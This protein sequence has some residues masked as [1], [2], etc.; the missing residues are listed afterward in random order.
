MLCIWVRAW[1][2]SGEGIGFLAA[3]TIPN[4]LSIERPSSIFFW[5]V[6]CAS[7]PFFCRFLF[8]FLFCF[9]FSFSRWNFVTVDDP[10]LFTC[11]AD[12]V[13]VWQPRMSVLS[14]CLLYANSGCGK[15]RRILIGPWLPAKAALVRNRLKVYWPCAGGLSAVNAIGTQL[16]DPI[17]SELTR[18][19]M[20]VINK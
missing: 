9:C 20:T 11:P 17:N 7:V 3:G 10:L 2:P 5:H 4:S 13:P 15:E 8:L 1:L 12:H 19:R 6:L 16:R 18:W 14:T